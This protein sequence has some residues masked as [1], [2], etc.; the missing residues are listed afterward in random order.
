MG[1]GHRNRKRA[2]GDRAMLAIEI[3]DQNLMSITIDDEYAVLSGD[4][5]AV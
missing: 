3:E 2:K 5:D 4:E 1:W